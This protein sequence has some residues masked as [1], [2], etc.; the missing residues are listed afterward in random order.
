MALLVLGSSGKFKCPIDS[1]SFTSDSEK[2]ISGL[3]SS[4]CHNVVNRENVLKVTVIRQY[5]EGKKFVCCICGSSIKTFPNFKRHFTVNHPDIKLISDAKCT[6]CKEE[7][8][9]AKGVSVHCI[10]ELGVSKKK[11][12]KK[13]PITPPIFCLPC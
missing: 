10:R 9:G 13:H 2:G 7:F 12:T 6:L 11:G 1:C 3:M 4:K 5:L 8:K